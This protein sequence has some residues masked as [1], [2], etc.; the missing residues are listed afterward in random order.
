MLI[1]KKFTEADKSVSG[2]REYCIAVKTK[3]SPLY[4]ETSAVVRAFTY[5]SGYYVTEEEPNLC[6]MHFFME[7]DLKIT[8]F[9]AKQTVPRSS[10]YANFIREY[11]HKKKGIV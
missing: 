4:P 8:M 2:K 3:P 11:I 5:L 10:N 7:A 9:I 6:Q 1:K